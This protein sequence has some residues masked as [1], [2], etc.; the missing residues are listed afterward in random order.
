MANKASTE[1]GAR[2]RLTGE[3]IRDQ[4]LGISGLLSRKMYGRPVMPY[5]P[6]N[7]WQVVYSGVEWKESQGEDAHR[8]AIY[9]FLRRSSPYPSML[10][11]D[12]STRDVCTARRIRTNTPLQALVTLN[13]S[14]FVEMA[15][16]FAK[17]MQKEGGKTIDSQLQKGYWLMTG[18]ALPPDKQRV[19]KQLYQDA[20]NKFAQ[21]K[22]KS[23]QWLGQ[24]NATASDAALAFVANTMLNM[25]EFITKE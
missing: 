7:V 11:F 8:R 3:Q 15:H 19:L 22:N 2:I 14:A 9:T 18:H 5:Q 17:R 20:L 6:P 1:R 13:D 25:D 16:H 21:N 10:T 24:T 4:A 23:S 12:G